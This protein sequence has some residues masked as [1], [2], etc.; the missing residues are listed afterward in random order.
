MTK[1]VKKEHKP[2]TT[3]TKVAE[4]TKPTTPSNYNGYFWNQI[5]RLWGSVQELQREND[6]LRTLL[7]GN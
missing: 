6:H 4:S 7:P 3:Q 1:G 2:T 5:E